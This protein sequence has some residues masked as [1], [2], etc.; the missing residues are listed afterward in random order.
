MTNPINY[1]MLVWPQGHQFCGAIQELGITCRAATASE[2]I[3]ILESRKIEVLAEFES[4]N[5]A[6][7]PRLDGDRVLDPLRARILEFLSRAAIVSVSIIIIM[8]IFFGAIKTVVPETLRSV[9]TSADSPDFI[10]SMAQVSDSKIEKI[11]SDIHIVRTKLQPVF[12]E[13]SALFSQSCSS[14]EKK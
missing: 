8:G 1:R 9:F 14:Q 10:K 6:L 2:V 4:Y 13:L 11:R 7:P 3:S 12:L 5:I